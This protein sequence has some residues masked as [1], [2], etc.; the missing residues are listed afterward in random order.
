VIRFNALKPFHLRAASSHIASG[1]D[2]IPFVNVILGTR[3]QFIKTA[4][5]LLEMDRRHI[6]YRLFHTGQHTE[7][8]RTLAILFGVRAADYYLTNKAKD[9]VSVS[10][11]V[12][13]FFSCLLSGLFLPGTRTICATRAVMVHGDT[14]STL[15]GAVLAFAW[16]Q[17]LI[18]IESGLTTGHLLLPFPEEIIRRYVNRQAFLLFPP[19]RWS[20][21]NLR[22]WS[23]RGTIVCTD[24]NTVLDSVRLIA[25]RKQ[26]DGMA[27]YGV[28]TLHR[29]ETFLN[30]NAAESAVE[31][32]VAASR[33]HRLTFVLHKFTERML[34][35][36]GFIPR[37]RSARIETLGNL[38]YHEFMTL[39]KNA[40]FVITD[41]GGMQEETYY[42]NVPCLILRTY[43][44]RVEGLS[45]TAIVSKMS[46]D[47]VV[48]FV[49]NVDSFSHRLAFDDFWPSRTIV[50]A[51]ESLGS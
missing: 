40:R 18:H 1:S 36:Y 2:D 29:N 3:G 30:R 27:P 7:S 20:Q 6:R 9:M 33:V 35:R 25:P 37:L 15:I 4:P 17:K 43:T 45:T 31:A 23:V 10:R 49:K 16:R 11:A 28:V 39:V 51:I 44:E 46:I 13:W 48:D 8:T 14:L 12:G 24:A 38:P 34:D 5:V 19:N 26:V 22:R 41:G 42:M 32:L 47:T 50:D 21:E